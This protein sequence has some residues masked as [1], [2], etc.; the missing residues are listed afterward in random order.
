MRTIHET[1][2]E[3]A[4]RRCHPAPQRSGRSLPAEETDVPKWTAGTLW[5]SVPAARGHHPDVAVL[6]VRGEIDLGT[7][8]ALREALLPLLERETGPVVVDL[9]EIEFMDSIGLH[10]LVD[11]LRR[12]EPQNRRFAI[13][14]REGGHL[15][16]LLALV[17]LLGGL[18]VHRA[19]ESAVIGGDD[20]L[21]SGPARARRPLEVR[22]PTSLLSTR[23]TTELDQSR[24]RYDMDRAGSVRTASDDARDARRGPCADLA[25]ATH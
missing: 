6:D 16:R 25:M 22:A 7:A 24:S 23:Q 9:S 11:T 1:N 13:V 4:D 17:G 14:C 12:L 8:P 2:E 21:R 3:A 18:T 15:H 20:V 5:V 19:L 10:V